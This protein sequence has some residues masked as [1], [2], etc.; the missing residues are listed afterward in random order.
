MCNPVGFI[1]IN[2]IKIDKVSI[3]V[4]EEIIHFFNSPLKYD[5]RLLKC[6][7]IA[8]ICDNTEICDPI[9]RY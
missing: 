4:S 6:S 7:I 3:A 9:F 1:A 2:I 8:Y 5:K